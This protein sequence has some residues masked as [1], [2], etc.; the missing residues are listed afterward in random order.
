MIPKSNFFRC[1]VETI[2]LNI[3]LSGIILSVITDTV[4]E[5]KI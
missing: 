3:F 2:S 4:I 1:Q 5:S